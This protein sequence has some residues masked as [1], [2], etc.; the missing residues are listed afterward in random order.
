MARLADRR[1]VLE[2]AIKMW[3]LPQEYRMDN[4]IKLGKVTLETIKKLTNTLIKFHFTTP[5][6]SLIKNFGKPKYME[7]KIIENFITQKANNNR[8]KI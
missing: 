1:H 7:M 8:S 6:N 4:L 3:G 2:H 5:T